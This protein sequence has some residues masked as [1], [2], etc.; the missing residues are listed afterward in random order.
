[1]ADRD[2][3][4]FNVIFL[5]VFLGCSA[6][7]GGFNN[8]LPNK[9]SPGVYVEDNGKT[10]YTVNEN[11][12]V[13]M[14]KFDDDDSPYKGIVSRPVDIKAC[15]EILKIQENPS[16]ILNKRVPLKTRLCPLV[17]FGI[18]FYFGFGHKRF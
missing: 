11:F 18:G 4:W 5:A 7:I 15:Q 1:M 2:H 8:K 16:T 9:F 10:V 3:S 12:F 13:T 6:I 17:F 14:T